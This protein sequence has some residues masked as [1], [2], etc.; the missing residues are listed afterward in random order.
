MKLKYTH[1]NNELTILNLNQSVT[2]KGWV[3]KKRNLGGLIFI[4]LKDKEGVTQIMVKPD[5]KN[6]ETAKELKN[7]YVIEVKGIIAKRESA[8][9]SILTGQIEVIAEELVVLSMANPLPIQTSDDDLSL[10]DTR[11]KY[12]YLDLRK[13]K[14]QQKLITRHKITQSIRNTLLKNNFLELETPILGIS[15]PEGARDYLVPSRLYNGQFYALPQSP[16]IFKQLFMVAGYERYFQVARCFRDEDLRADRQPEFT[17]VDIEASFIEQKHIVKL[18]ETVFKNLF[19]D[20]LKLKLKTPFLKMTYKKAMS[21]YGTDK[22]DLR[23]DLKIQDYSFLAKDKD[24]PLLFNK[25]AIKGILIDNNDLITRKKIDEYTNLVKKNH[26]E[27]L[28]YLK[29]TNGELSG[30]LSKF[31]TNLHLIPQNK[32]LFICCGK[33]LKDTLNALGALRIQLGNDLNLIDQTKHAF[34]WIVDW[35]LFEYSKEEQR[36]FAMHHPFTSPKNLD[37]FLKN[38]KK[39]LANAYDIV[40]NGYEVGGGSI[41]IHNQDTQEQM[42]K[43]LGF[44]KEEIIEKFGFFVEALKYGTPPHGGLALGLDRICMLATNTTNIKD[45]ISFPKTQSARDLMMEAPGFVETKQLEELGI[46]YE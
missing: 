40:W 6:Y 1:H 16:Q 31:I 27:A 21:L 34:V 17:Q 14:M 12:R 22:P 4:D 32:T 19:K 15:T 42:F 38:P 9:S 23:F 18:T 3:S 36:F 25:K 44:S 29:N 26:G 24:I 2:L 39:A 33:E 45:V 13:P 46:I 30:S 37:I 11:L 8:N 20:V 43:T 5:N 7:E 28:A 41:R 10:E 35:P